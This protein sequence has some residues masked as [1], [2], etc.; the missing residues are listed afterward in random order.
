MR[1]LVTGGAGFIGSQV[2]EA[3]LRR[4]DEVAVVDSL[5]SGRAEF[6]PPG[7]RF[8]EMDIRDPAIGD[9]VAEVRPHLI[10]HH[11]AQAS[12]SVSMRDPVRDADVNVLGTIRLAAAAAAAGVPHFIFAST[13]GALY[14]EPERLP[15]DESTP[16]APLSPYGCA[17][18]V[19]EA[20]L[21]LYRRLHGLRV[22]C[23]RYANVFGP[24]QDPHGEAGVVAI[25]ARAMLDGRPATI[26]GDGE[27]TRDFVFVEDA[28][29]ANLLAADRRAEGA[30]NIGTGEATTVNAI[31][32]LLARLT[33]TTAAPTYA[34]P[35]PGDVRHVTL[36][37]S[38]ARRLLGWTPAVSLDAG[39]AATVE[40]F[41]RHS[42]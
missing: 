35:R 31:Y 34:P 22:C 27:Q 41:R 29:R 12:V 40:W 13:G 28:V 33:G 36:D 19:A 24:R 8:Y 37:A 16:I 6:V 10:N 3:H 42:G 18:A 15:A 2:A 39:L 26:Y 17:K 25:F 30:V 9:V 11:A 38:A 1:V 32:R 23:L 21:A 4:G 20:Y 5:V 7:A 14:G